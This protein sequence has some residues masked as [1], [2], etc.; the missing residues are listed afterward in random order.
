[1]TATEPEL[2]FRLGYQG[3]LGVGPGW[4]IGAQRAE[5]A[6]RIVQITGD[7]AVG[8]HIQELDTMVRHGLPIVTVVLSNDTWGMSIHGQDAVFGSGNDIITRLAPTR[9]ERVAEAFGGYGER[10]EQLA[11]VGPVVRRALDS[12]RPARSP[13]L[14]S[15]T[16]S[17]TTPRSAA[18]APPATWR[19]P[20]CS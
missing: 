6:R 16:N 3:H 2:V 10:V 1:M 12:G 20:R 7:G 4:A 11:D 15:R 9:Y 19:P 5:P 18:S 17:W 13:R 8:F 14:R